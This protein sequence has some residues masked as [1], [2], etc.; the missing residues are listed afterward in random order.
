MSKTT[1]QAR[2]QRRAYELWLKKTN[3]TA[4]KE[5]KSQSTER[6]KSLME[7][8]EEKVR[9]VETAKLEKAQA[10]LI[11]RL[12]SEGKTKEEIDRHVSIWALTIKPWGTSEKR[13]SWKEAEKQYELE[14]KS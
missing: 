1:S 14:L 2:K 4:Y 3:P 6:G 9:E 13:I 8:Q 10:E 12:E 5:W 11:N 7:Q